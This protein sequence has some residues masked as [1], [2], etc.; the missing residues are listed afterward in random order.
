MA[1]KVGLIESGALLSINFLPGA[2]YS[3]GACIKLTLATAHRLDFPLNRL[4]FEITEAERIRDYDHLLSI[5]E[6]YKKHGF[7]IALDDLGS[8]YSGLNL[9]AGLHVDVV[10]LDAELTRDIHRRP[11]ARAIV[12]AMVAVAAELGAELIAE[13]IETIEEYRTLTDCGVILMQGYL[14]ARPGFERLPAVVYPENMLE[15][16]CARHPG[17]QPE[18]PHA[19]PPSS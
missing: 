10:K 13:G 9:L 16:V 5:V 17:K 18:L 6:E 8:G 7:K 15:S 1:K 4:M 12:R 11:A 3:P 2:V 14:F 19:A